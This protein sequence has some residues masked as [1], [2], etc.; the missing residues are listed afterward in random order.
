MKKE[1]DV[2]A[3]LLPV[4]YES[5]PLCLREDEWPEEPAPCGLPPVTGVTVTECFAPHADGGS[6][7]T[8]VFAPQ[9]QQGSLPGLLWIHGGGLYCGVPECDGEHCASLACETGCVVVAPDYRL[10]P[11][12]PYP[13]GLE[14][15]YDTLLWMAENAGALGIDRDRIA[16]AGHSAGGGLTAA[17]TLLNRERKKV[18][19]LCQIL[20]SPMLDDRNET[21]SCREITAQT[22]PHRWNRDTNAVAWR[23]YLR[24]TAGE[25][26]I[27]AAPARADDLTELPPAYLLVGE[28]DPF[29]D[30][31]I[32]YA[33]KLT[34]AE[35]PAEL[36]VYPRCFHGFEM[37]GAQYE[38]SRRAMAEAFGALRRAFAG[39]F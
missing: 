1:T 33:T 13:A 24:E 5:E 21:Q 31:T 12:H 27:Y 22:F 4:L 23:W 29:R 2:R 11:H 6:V 25:P 28:L 34:Q 14:D 38:V 37:A 8:L 16:V 20:L 30:E 3:E 39:Q 17:L 9:T 26:P 32:A 18:K 36:H 7:R 19:L 15:C 35:V 10:A